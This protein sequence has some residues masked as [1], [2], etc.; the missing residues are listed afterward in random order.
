MRLSVGT[1]QTVSFVLNM[2]LRRPVNLLLVKPSPF[3][4]ALGSFSAL[5]RS[6]SQDVSIVH[7]LLK[8]LSEVRA[9]ILRVVLIDRLLILMSI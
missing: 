2:P 7:L 8:T 4:R 1:R 3:L 9:L 6:S 5:C